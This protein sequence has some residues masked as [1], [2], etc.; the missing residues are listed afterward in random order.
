MVLDILQRLG[1][2]SP[3]LSGGTGVVLIEARD[4]MRSNWPT[5]SVQPLHHSASQGVL[6]SLRPV[7]QRPRDPGRQGL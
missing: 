6:G 1:S 7:L 3:L 2:G 4:R 5:N